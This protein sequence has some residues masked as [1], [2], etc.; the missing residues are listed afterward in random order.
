MRHDISFYLT[1]GVDIKITLGAIN[2]IFCQSQQ[3]LGHNIKKGNLKSCLQKLHLYIQLV[4]DVRKKFF[5]RVF[6]FK[7]QVQA[8]KGLK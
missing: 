7:S 8:K 5:F 3:F 6:L 4:V 2:T 1:G